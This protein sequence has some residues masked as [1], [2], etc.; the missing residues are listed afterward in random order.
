MDTLTEEMMTGMGM[1]AHLSPADERDWTL[2]AV[3]APTTYPASCFI[4]LKWRVASMQ[5]QIGCCVGCTFEEIVAQIVHA[6]SQA[7]GIPYQELSF[8]FVYAVCKCLDGIEDQGTYPN[9]A[10]KVV[11]TY[12]VPLAI[13]CPNDVTLDH[14]T[15]VYQRNLANIPAA[16][17]ADALTR[18]AGADITVPLTQEGI[19]QAI[20]YAKAN[21]GGVAILRSIGNTY[22][23]APDGTVTYDPAKLLPIRVQTQTVSGHEE[24]LYGYDFE[25]TTNRMRIYWLNHWSPSWA[26]KGRGWEY[27]DVW[28]KNIGEIRV[29]VAAIPTN[30]NFTYAFKSDMKKGMQGPDVVALQHVLK[31]EGFFPE[32]QAFTGYYGDVTFNAVLQLQNKYKAEILTPIGLTYGTGNVG[33]AT[34]K[35]LNAK[36]NK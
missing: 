20:T 29:V 30:P 1:G 15:F 21:N 4:D 27:V 17:F 8:R 13:Y 23:T 3:G 22:W 35:W 11:R 9:L 24:F 2:A 36:Y 18:R 5:G 12:G 16:A 14:E 10:A 25:P 6:M 26:A 19:Q 31:I 32:A 28:L 7:T 33:D 34:L